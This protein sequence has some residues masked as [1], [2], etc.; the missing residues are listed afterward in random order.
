M[1]HKGRQRTKKS[2]KFVKIGK[3]FVKFVKIGGKT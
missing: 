1:V 2:V 3:K